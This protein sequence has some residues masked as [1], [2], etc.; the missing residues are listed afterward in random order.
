MEQREQFAALAHEQWS[1]WMEYLLSMC[2]PNTD[3]SLTIPPALVE[4]WVRQ[5]NT[6]YAELP[7]A[8]KESDRIEADKMIAVM[9]G[10][11]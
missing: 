4:R 8:E 11:R 2:I 6:P 1:G 9:R 5:M 7:E 3:G 10:E